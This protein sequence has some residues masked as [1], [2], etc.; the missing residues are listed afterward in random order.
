MVEPNSPLGEKNIVVLQAPAKVNLTLEI[1]GKRPDGYH[2]LRS[3]LVP[4]SL[5]DTVTL[6]EIPGPGVEVEM[7]AKGVDISGM[8]G[9]NVAARAARLFQG[10]TG[11]SRG[12][13]IRIMKRIP[14]G[15]G[16]GGGSADAAAVLK[17]LQTLWGAPLRETMLLSMAAEL[18]S[19]I[20]AMVLGGAVMMEGRGEKVRRIHVPPGCGMWIIIANE[21]THCSTAEVYGRYAVEK[22]TPGNVKNFSQDIVLPLRAGDVYWTA[23]FLRNDLQWTVYDLHL[24]IALLARKMLNEEAPG[25]QLC[26][27]GASV[28]AL[29]RSKAQGMRIRKSLKGFANWNVLVQTLP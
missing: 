16:L 21:G 5:F 15:G 4:V 10:R 25:V 24:N 17:G 14:L 11:V 1:L 2:E 8:S 20:P 26:G 7:R 3:V 28:F 9:E 19:D 23:N 18:G 29:V 6:E 13:R 12:A 27:S 22:R